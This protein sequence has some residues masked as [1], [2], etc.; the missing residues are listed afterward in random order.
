MG[1]FDLRE[2]IFVQYDADIVCFLFLRSSEFWWSFLCKVFHQKCQTM[3]FG[4]G[5]YGSYLVVLTPK[6]DAI[7][8]RLETPWQLP[9]LS[10]RDDGQQDRIHLCKFHLRQ[11]LEVLEKN[12]NPLEG[13]LVVSVSELLFLPLK[14]YFWLKKHKH[15]LVTAS[16]P[17]YHFKIAED[18]SMFF[19]AI[20]FIIIHSIHLSSIFVLIAHHPSSIPCNSTLPTS[21][22]LWGP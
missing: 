20:H 16:L 21:N 3:L 1:L 8:V 5:L 7:T 14:P 15:Q 13:N 2:K 19:N 22:R 4:C 6:P 17:T 9:P 18:N 11:L 10:P 12:T